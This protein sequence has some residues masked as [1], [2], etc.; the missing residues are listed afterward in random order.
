[1]SGR[2]KTVF[3]AIVPPPYVRRVINARRREWTERYGSLPFTWS[4]TE[5]LITIASLG[6]V[7]DVRLPSLLSQVKTAV[8]SCP[9]FDFALEIIRLAPTPETAK[10]LWLATTTPSPELAR[11]CTAIARVQSPHHPELAPQHAHITM[12][13][14]DRAALRR[15]N[16]PADAFIYPTRVTVAVD[17]VIVYETVRIGTTREIVTLEHLPLSDSCGTLELL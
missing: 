11:L 4:Q 5:P 3:V 1:M 7:E 16:P 2:T 10:M 9:S 6:H 12:A 8:Q 15:L 14:V 13:R 17:S